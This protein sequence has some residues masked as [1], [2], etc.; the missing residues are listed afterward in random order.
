MKILSRYIMLMLMMLNIVTAAAVTRNL[1]VSTSGTDITAQLRQAAKGLG[2]DDNLVLTLGKG[3]YYIG[4][5]VNI[6]C[7]FTLT[8][9][10][11]KST[12]LVCKH[13]ATDRKA[14][15]ST[16]P[17]DDSYLS[18]KGTY[19]N[20]ITVNI[21]D[22]RMEL[23]KHNN[24]DIWW[25]EAEPRHLAKIY[26]GDGINIQRLDSYCANAFCNNLDFRI[27]NN[28]VI[29]D[30]NFVNYNNCHAGAIFAVRGNTE[31]VTITNNTFDKYGNDEAVTFIGRYHNAEYQSGDTAYAPSVKR[32]IIITNNTFNYG[33]GFNSRNGG[34][35]TP[36]DL[37]F[38]F[39]LHLNK[40]MPAPITTENFK[41][42]NNTFNLYDRVARLIV[43]G[44][45]QYSYHKGVSFSNNTFNHYSGSS[46]TGTHCDDFD[47][48]DESKSPND[49]VVIN[50][51]IFN[52]QSE[53]VSKWNTPNH[54]ILSVCKQGHVA[55]NNNTVKCSISKSSNT[56]DKRYGVILLHADEGGG[57]VS[58]SNNN[59]SGL[60][61]LG[62]FA[63]SATINSFTVNA[64]R[65]TFTG[66]TRI[67]CKNI[68]ELNLNFSSNTFNSSD[69]TF[70]LERFANSGTV[71]FTNNIVNCNRSG[72]RLFT[73]WGDASKARNMTFSNLT[74][75]GNTFRGTTQTKLLEHIK[76][77]HGRT[78]WNNR[79]Q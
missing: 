23:A 56:S 58:M 28:L 25:T 26:N 62:Q 59:V 7:N 38:S 65:N 34:G 16:Y 35:T 79:F 49:D 13:D 21:S 9:K 29:K 63:S 68:E 6:R 66:D 75:T 73:Y 48:Q 44:F 8:G 1:D 64:S 52:V 57:K 70:F 42:E 36:C 18:I 15:G 11:M 33:K 4:G 32:N 46:A 2:N 55:F 40:K 37:Y 43:T 20:R 78:I 14:N 54:T 24:G 53:V 61:V 69:A 74:V 19:Y 50:G 72:A 45:D 5:T 71:S 51:N 67:Y 10:G 76:S 60:Y 27:C 31:N 12:T 77:I 41:M 17:M 22:L 3:T 47:I 39:C 30:C